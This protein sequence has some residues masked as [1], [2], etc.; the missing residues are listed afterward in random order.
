MYQYNNIP[1]SILTVL[2]LGK[3]EVQVCRSRYWTLVHTYS[4]GLDAELLLRRIE[5]ERKEGDTNRYRIIQTA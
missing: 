4:N 1:C 3:F 2:G 5:N